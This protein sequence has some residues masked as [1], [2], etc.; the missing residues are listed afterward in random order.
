MTQLGPSGDVRFRALH[1]TGGSRRNIFANGGMV[2]AFPFVET[3]MIW[4][5]F[6]FATGVLLALVAA[7][8]GLFVVF[9]IIVKII[10]FFRYSLPRHSSSQRSTPQKSTD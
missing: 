1:L 7:A 8:V 3:Q 10:D 5:G 4:N 9:V 2:A 6:L